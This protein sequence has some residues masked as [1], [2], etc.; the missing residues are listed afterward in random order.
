MANENSPAMF[1]RLDGLAG[2]SGD[3]ILL[4]GRILMGWVFLKV[5]WDHVM[6]PA[7]LVG[8]LTFLGAPSPAVLAWPALI[9][10]LVIGVGL[11]LG[12]AT[13]Y[14]AVLTVIWLIIATWLAHRYWVYPAAVPGQPAPSNSSGNQFAHMLKNLSM[15]GGALVLFVTGAGRISIDARMK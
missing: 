4:I 3:V 14:V 15:I 5:G 10:E 13:R 7:S 1:N 2:S 6:N 8:Y 11:I 9:A 12:I